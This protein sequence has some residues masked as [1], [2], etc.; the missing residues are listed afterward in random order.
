MSFYMKGMEEKKF[1]VST[2][3]QHQ[4]Q[5]KNSLSGKFS[6]WLLRTNKTFRFVVI[7]GVQNL[8]FYLNSEMEKQE[9]I[10]ELNVLLN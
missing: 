7:N 4:L 1:D 2:N 6:N 5:L 10:D 3:I 9:L 8:I